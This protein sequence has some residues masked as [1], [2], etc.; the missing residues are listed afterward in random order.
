MLTKHETSIIK[1][2]E[3]E[4]IDTEIFGMKSFSAFKV[5]MFADWKLNFPS[6]K[7]QQQKRNKFVSVTM[8]THFVL[9]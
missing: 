7:I 3:T 9:G 6:R 4:K 1:F 2:V 5:L 8:Q